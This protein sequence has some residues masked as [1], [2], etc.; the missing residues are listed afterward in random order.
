MGWTA[1][2]I[3]RSWWRS[4]P[5]S[6]DAATASC[7]S[8][9]GHLR[10]HLALAPRTGRS[11]RRMRISTSCAAC[12]CCH[13][14]NAANGVGVPDTL[15]GALERDAQQVPTAWSST[16]ATQSSMS[17]HVLADASVVT[18]AWRRSRGTQPRAAHA[19]SPGRRRP[20]PELNPFG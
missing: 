14:T 2:S 8:C 10:T 18:P 1:G 19:C 7:E 6:S 9:V 17:R 4:R 11:T 12:C 20:S 15:T 13:S 5:H 3:R 16:A